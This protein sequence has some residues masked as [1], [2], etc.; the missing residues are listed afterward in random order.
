MMEIENLLINYGG[1]GIF[2]AYLIIQERTT[3]KRTIHAL[4]NNT[5]ALTTFTEVVRKCKK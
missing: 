4:D 5:Q 3:A 1:I 2:T